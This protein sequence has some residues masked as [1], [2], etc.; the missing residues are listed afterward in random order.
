[1]NLSK[2]TSIVRPASIALT[3]LVVGVVT[4]SAGLSA[5]ADDFEHHEGTKSPIKHVIILIGEN[6]T[7]DNVYGTYVPKRGQSVSNLLSKGIVNAYGSP[8]PNRNVA[9]QFT[10]ETIDPVAFSSTKN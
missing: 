2:P 5:Y 1:M 9:K 6:R 8:G 4:Q 7:F 3:S 10:I